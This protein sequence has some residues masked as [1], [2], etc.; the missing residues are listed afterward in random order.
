MKTAKTLEK[1]I[2]ILKERGMSIENEG[3]ACE[4]LLDIGYYRIGFYAFF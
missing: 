1:Q 3:K 2:E 4:S